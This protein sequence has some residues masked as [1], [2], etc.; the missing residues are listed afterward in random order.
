MNSQRQPKSANK[1]SSSYVN[2]QCIE[3]IG[4]CAEWFTC[5]N[6]TDCDDHNF[7][8]GVEQCI[9]GTC[10]VFNAT[11]CPGNQTCDPH[12]GCNCNTDNTAL[13]IVIGVF[14]A[15][16]VALAI[17]IIIIFAMRAPAASDTAG[18]ATVAARQ[19]G[20]NMRTR[21]NRMA[22]RNFGK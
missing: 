2:V 19:G 17:I 12:C 20:E 6:N 3:E 10:R 21:A 11:P 18:A 7:C 13:Y 16:I 1:V 15:V 22:L 14:V 4:A 8:N 9:N 5:L